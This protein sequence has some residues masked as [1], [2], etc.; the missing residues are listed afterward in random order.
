M[1]AG[2]CNGIVKGRVQVAVAAYWELGCPPCP[3]YLAPPEVILSSKDFYPWITFALAISSRVFMSIAVRAA[4]KLEQ[5]PVLLTCKSVV[6]V[7]LCQMIPLMAYTG[8]R[9]VPRLRFYQ[10]S[11]RQLKIA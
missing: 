10:P 4:Q 5:F 11:D 8:N 3:K 6:G 1:A 9:S 7:Y 2:V